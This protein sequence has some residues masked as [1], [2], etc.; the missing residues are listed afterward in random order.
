MLKKSICL[1]S[2]ASL[3]GIM[4]ACGGATSTTTE[5]ADNTPTVEAPTE[6]ATTEVVAEPTPEPTPTPEEVIEE[7]LTEGRNYY[8]GLNGVSTDN[9]KALEAFQKAADLDSADAFYY[10]GRIHNRAEEYDEAKTAY[11]KAIELGNSMAKLALGDYYNFGYGVEKDYAKAKE[12]YEAAID[13]GCIEA[14]IGLGWIYMTGDGVDADLSKAI[15]YLELAASSTELEWISEAY[16]DLR[17]IYT[18]YY[19]EKYKDEKKV[20]ELKVSQIVGL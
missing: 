3:L 11:D 18:G 14:N 7:A 16:G 9:D 2:I 17:D 6:E 5:V 13:E 15:E 1:L 10:I 20:D 12:L 8:Y 4:T 19:D